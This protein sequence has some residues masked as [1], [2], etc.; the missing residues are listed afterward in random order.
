MASDLPQALKN[1]G[2]REVGKKGSEVGDGGVRAE[3]VGAELPGLCL[4]LRWQMFDEKPELL[5]RAV[6]PQDYIWKVEFLGAVV[7]E[8]GA[9][10]FFGDALAGDEASAEP[11]GV[12]LDLHASDDLVA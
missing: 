10:C 8:G 3:A 2:L 7:R 6:A 11:L 1:K 4:V 12:A 5:A 9:G